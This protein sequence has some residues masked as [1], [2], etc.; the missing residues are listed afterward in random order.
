MIVQ[1]LHEEA[2]HLLRTMIVGRQACVRHLSTEMKA[3]P[4]LAIT[5]MARTIVEAIDHATTH[6]PRV[7]FLDSAVADRENLAAIRQLAT[8]RALVIVSDRPDFAFQAFECGAIDYLLKPVPSDRIR[9]TLQRIKQLFANS[10]EWST[11]ADAASSPPRL[12]ITDRVSIPSRQGTQGKSA[13]LVPVCDVIWIESLQNYSIV[14]LSGGER[15]SIKRT[16]TE[17]EALLPSREFARLGRSYLVQ[18][19]KL[20]T[21]TSPG[22]DICLAHFH[23]VAQPLQLGRAPASKLKR[24]VRASCPA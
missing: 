18:V 13:A 11:D 5:C 4:N 14:Q 6:H 2:P 19:A 16:L 3:H 15:R 22:R 17:W 24:I 20:R 10:P 7:I 12:T 23:D 21:V 1:R 8:G 9:G